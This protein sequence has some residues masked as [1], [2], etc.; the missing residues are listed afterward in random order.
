V[1]PV[2]PPPG[3]YAPAKQGNVKPKQCLNRKYF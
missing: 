3:S 2:P 1:A